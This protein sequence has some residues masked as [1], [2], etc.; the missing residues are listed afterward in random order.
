MVA[1]SPGGS[2][3]IVTGG[4]VNVKVQGYLQA[5]SYKLQAT[6]SESGIITG[7]DHDGRDTGR[8]KSCTTGRRRRQHMFAKM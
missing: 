4:Q 1:E 7:P 3:G 5:T 2:L 6:S 8:N